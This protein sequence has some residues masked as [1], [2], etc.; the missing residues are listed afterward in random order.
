MEKSPSIIFFDEIDALCPKRDDNATDL[1][2]RVVATL[3]T[4]IDGTFMPNRG[5]IFV[6]GATNRANHIDDSLRRP[7]RFDRELEIGK[8]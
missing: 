4:L 3:L 7:G 1:E 6:M 5:G 8:L 2:K